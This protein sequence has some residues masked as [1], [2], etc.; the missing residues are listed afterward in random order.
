MSE[1]V[2]DFFSGVPCQSLLSTQF[3][4]KETSANKETLKEA[5]AE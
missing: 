2:E 5:E 3:P 4:L 1:H